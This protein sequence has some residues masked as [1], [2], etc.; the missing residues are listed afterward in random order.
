MTPEGFDGLG[1]PIP[2]VGGN[3]RRFFEA[4]LRGPAS[5]PTGSEALAEGLTMVVKENPAQQ[6]IFQGAADPATLR[7]ESPSLRRRAAPI[8]EGCRCV[9]CVLLVIR[10]QYKEAKRFEPLNALEPGGP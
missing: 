7:F 6:R 4:P 1:P 9:Q 2:G 10:Q 3:G 8:Q 5:E